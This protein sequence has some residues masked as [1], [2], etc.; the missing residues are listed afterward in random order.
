EIDLI[1]EIARLHGYNKFANS[2]PRFSGAVIE[3]P[4]TAKQAK[5]RSSLLALGYDEA[6]SL[7]FISHE[8][9]ETFSSSPVI[10]LANPISEAACLMG[11]AL[12]PGMLD[13]LSYNLNRG[14]E[15]VRLFEMG[16]IYEAAGSWTAEKSRIC[17]G[18]TVAA[19]ENE[20]PQGAAL[21][22]S[23]G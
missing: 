17:L 19:I 13:M 16:D 18:A 20:L 23:K 21:D 10:E 8:D 11:G 7:S 6:I 5:L 4:Q 22:K 9:A 15:K 14:T 2:L 12:V 1:E 3:R